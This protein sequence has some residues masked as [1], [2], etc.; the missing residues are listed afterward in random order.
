MYLEALYGERPRAH[1]G[2]HAVQLLVIITVL[3]LLAH[4]QL[5]QGW[6]PNIDMTL[7]EQ[8]SAVTK[9][10]GEQQSPDMSAVDICICQKNHLHMY[11]V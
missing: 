5:V 10:E 3:C 6:D 4:V 9:K 8:R 1:L 2:S 11:M 7:L